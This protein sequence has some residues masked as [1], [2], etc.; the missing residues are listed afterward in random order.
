MKL[1]R[2]AGTVAVAAGAALI[3]SLSSAAH[4][5]TASPTTASADSTW[6]WVRSFS[7]FEVCSE[8]GEHYVRYAEAISY[9]CDWDG[10][11]YRL[12]VEYP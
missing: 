4:A 5:T 9:R 7:T 8:I 1:L 6:K 12:L 3:L 10:R 11:Q 2:I